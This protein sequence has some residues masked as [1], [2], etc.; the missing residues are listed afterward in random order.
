MVQKVHFSGQ[1]SYRRDL[2]GNT[3][4]LR[5]AGLHQPDWAGFPQPGQ[6]H[7]PEPSAI[8]GPPPQGPHQS[9]CGSCLQPQI[10]ANSSHWGFRVQGGQ[11]TV[12][13]P[14]RGIPADR[15]VLRQGG[16]LNVWTPWV[17]GHSS[18]WILGISAWR[19]QEAETPP[20]LLA[21]PHHRPRLRRD[22]KRNSKW[23]RRP[24][25]NLRQK[26]PAG[27]PPGPAASGPSSPGRS[28]GIQP[29]KGRKERTWVLAQLCLLF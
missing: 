17:S 13:F 16:G 11:E 19:Q 27:T 7:V 6:V 20:G 23:Y 29:P 25:G 3:N 2:S 5:P 28:R 8:H 18:S 26:S 4:T 14:F 24:L 10:Q 1:F 9:P 12:A 21:D 22:N 15:A